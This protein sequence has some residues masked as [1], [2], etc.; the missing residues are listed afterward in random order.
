MPVVQTKHLHYMQGSHGPA[1]K[2]G[3]RL[4]GTKVFPGKDG[5]LYE[6][7]GTG[8]WLF[9]TVGGK[10]RQIDV[11]DL[12]RE[13]IKTKGKKSFTKPIRDAIEHTRPTQVSVTLSGNDLFIDQT[14]IDAW[15]AC[16]L[17]LI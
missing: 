17:P 12:L 10:D 7:T 15:A 1:G 5:K 14:S 2:K 6:N 8:Y 9:V 13:K 16:F 3:S 4:P 11:A